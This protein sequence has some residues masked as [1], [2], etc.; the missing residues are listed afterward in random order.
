MGYH[1]ILLLHYKL[2]DPDYFLLFQYLVMSDIVYQW[3][4]SWKFKL[5]QLKLSKQQKEIKIKKSDGEKTD[6]LKTVW[7]VS[8]NRYALGRFQKLRIFQETWAT[9][10]A[11]SAQHSASK[12]QAAL[13]RLKSGRPNVCGTVSWIN[14]WFFSSF[15]NFLN[16]FYIYFVIAY[17]REFATFLVIEIVICKSII[18]SCKSLYFERRLTYF[19]S[20]MCE[21]NLS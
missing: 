18:I 21:A 19:V 11:F 13:E 4:K 9:L 2:I 16:M 14:A 3:R 12:I 10:A 7:K 8:G 6:A 15:L 20:I 1:F 17:K 5:N